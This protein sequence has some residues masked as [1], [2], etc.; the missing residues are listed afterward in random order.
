[1]GLGAALHRSAAVLAMLDW[2]ARPGELVGPSYPTWY[3]SWLN[4]GVRFN[5]GSCQQIWT[6][7]EEVACLLF[8][9]KSL[10]RANHFFLLLMG[11]NVLVPRKSTPVSAAP[12]NAER[13]QCWTRRGSWMFLHVLVVV[14]LFLQHNFRALTAV[15]RR[16]CAIMGH[17]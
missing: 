4:E 13:S 8:P 5:S 10:W 14:F 6:C 17:L 2:N 15:L 12:G 3:D 16:F 11:L 1:M 7:W 9:W